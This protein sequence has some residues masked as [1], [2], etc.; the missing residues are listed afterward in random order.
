[1]SKAALIV[2]AGSGL[3]AMTF[4]RTVT[5]FDGTGAMGAP[6]ENFRQLSTWLGSED[7]VH[8][9]MQCITVP[10]V[11]Y[12]AVWAASN[13]DRVYWD[14][15]GAE[16]LGYKPRQNSEDYAA[17]IMKKPNPLD[18]VAQKHQGGQFVTMDYTPSEKRPTKR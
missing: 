16:K 14:N 17:E 13:N 7:L 2:G 11:G 12:M 3:S 15:T 9:I 1:M 10:D 4:A 5:V 18:P 8:L 6:P